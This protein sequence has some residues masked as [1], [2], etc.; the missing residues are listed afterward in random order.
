[1]LILQVSEACMLS[2]LAGKCCP[3]FKQDPG[4]AACLGASDVWRDSQMAANPSRKYSPSPMC[5]AGMAEVAAVP[6]HHPTYVRMSF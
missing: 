2:V 4:P 6:R 5:S 1:M 3:C